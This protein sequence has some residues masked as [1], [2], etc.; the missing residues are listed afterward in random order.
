MGVMFVMAGLIEEW[1]L[2]LLWLDVLFVAVI[3]YQKM[4]I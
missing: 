4:V 2:K 1:C 3:K